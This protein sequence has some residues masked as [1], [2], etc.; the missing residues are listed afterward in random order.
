[1]AIMEITRLTAHAFTNADE[2]RSQSDLL[3]QVENDGTTLVLYLDEVRVVFLCSCTVFR[4][5]IRTLDTSFRDNVVII[6]YELTFQN[7]FRLK[8]S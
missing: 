8:Y 4:D 2:L 3:K 7:N 5:K 6:L 1:M